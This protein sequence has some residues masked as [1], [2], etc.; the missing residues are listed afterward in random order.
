MQL[1][2][3]SGSPRRRDLL[4]DAGFEFIVL[5]ASVREVPRP[6][7][8]A[9]TVACRLSSEKALQVAASAPAG[10]VVLGA[11]TVVLAGSELLGK[12][13]DSQDAAGMLRKLSGVTHQ[14][15]TGVCLVSPPDRVQALSHETTLVTFRRLEE[16]E[17]ADY[18]ASGE[19]F[20]KAGAYAIQGLASRFVECIEGDLSNVVGLPV[21]LV[22]RMLKPHLPDAR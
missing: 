5:P 15:T 4:R 6:G 11:D 10:S 22:K 19:P 8:N 2:L 20:D 12:P 18:V 3:A 16:E 9:E 1:I 17:I 14:V 21:A 7:E 13:A